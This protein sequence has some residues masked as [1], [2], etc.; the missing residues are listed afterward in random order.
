MKKFTLLA[1][2]LLYVLFLSGCPAAGNPKSAES[3]ETA[4]YAIYPLSNFRQ[5][6]TFS[7]GA[8]YNPRPSEQGNLFGGDPAVLYLDFSTLSVKRSDNPLLTYITPYTFFTDEKYLYCIESD[9]NRL[10]FSRAN[11]DG[12]NKIDVPVPDSF[13]L[14]PVGGYIV[15]GSND[16]LYL[17][18]LSE[19]LSAN[20]HFT[21]A[22]VDFANKRI[23]ALSQIEAY[24]SDYSILGVIENA[25][26]IGEARLPD[27]LGGGIVENAL[28]F[29]LF[30]HHILQFSLEPLG[31]EILEYP[32]EWIDLID[33]EYHFTDRFNHT[34][35]VHSETPLG[36]AAVRRINYASNL[37]EM[38]QFD[39][40]EFPFDEALLH[41]EISLI[42]LAA[43]PDGFIVKVGYFKESLFGGYAFPVFGYISKTDYENG[44]FQVQLFDY[45]EILS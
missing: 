3:T 37:D 6:T 11:L 45:T 1:V 26:I 27:S 34:I 29:S 19:N 22:A 43:T 4:F 21:V 24:R 40:L 15:S 5:L 8:Y 17:L 42:P 14:A 35:Y 28:G 20:R 33:P 25:L 9:E 44:R 10:V 38:I 2:P 18:L 23:E 7:T 39:S 31:E 12:A 16:R 13:E 32:G 41:K 36:S 30:D